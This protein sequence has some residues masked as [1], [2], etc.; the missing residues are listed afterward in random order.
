MTKLGII[1]CVLVVTVFLIACQSTPTGSHKSPSAIKTNKSE[2]AIEIDRAVNAALSKLYETTPAAK[3]IQEKARGILVFPDVVKGGFI[4]GAQYG[5]GALR[6]GEE[7]VGYYNNIAAS[8]GLQAGVQGFG[9][10]LFFMNEDSLSYLEKSSGWEI[11][12]GPTIVVVDMGVAKTLTTSTLR[13]DVYA[14]IFDQRGLMA[15]LG[16]QGSKITKI[17]P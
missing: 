13:D 15:G 17:D 11:G 12:V 9:Y 10:A 7:T 1:F 4:F 16:I 2:A 14:F 3:I 8:Y 6:I 5:K